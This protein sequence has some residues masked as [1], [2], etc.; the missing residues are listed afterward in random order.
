M[1]TLHAAIR[2]T[3]TRRGLTLPTGLTSPSSMTRNSFAWSAGDV[4]WISSRKIVP[5]SAIWNSPG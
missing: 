1:S 3:S 5:P 4:F 2:R